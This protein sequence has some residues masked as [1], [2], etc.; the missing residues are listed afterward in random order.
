[1]GA[2]VGGALG[3]RVSRGRGGQTGPVRFAGVQ[4]RSSFPASSLSPDSASL[5]TACGGGPAG[6]G[7]QGH[8]GPV[9]SRSQVL[10]FLL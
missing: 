4:F 3:R 1:M 9:P 6:L 2:G 10:N 7:S 8:P 5:K